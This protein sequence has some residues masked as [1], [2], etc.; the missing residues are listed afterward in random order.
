M[1]SRP[2]QVSRTTGERKNPKPTGITL[3]NRG[4]ICCCYCGKQ[5]HFPE[6][7]C[8][9][10]QVDSRKVILQKEGRCFTC[11]MKG[12]LS[13]ECREKRESEMF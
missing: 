1:R 13:S 5:G 10:G 2:D 6:A 9:V 3:Y 8:V 4:N 11:L 12:H 7:C